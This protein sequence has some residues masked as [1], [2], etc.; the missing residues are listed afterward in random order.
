MGA[1]PHL[2]APADRQGGGGNTH[3]HDDERPVTVGNLSAARCQEYLEAGQ[4]GRVAWSAAHGPQIFPVSYAWC[5]DLIVFRT[6]PYSVLSE[7]TRRTHVVFEVEELD[8]VSHTGWSVLAR[9]CATGI[10]SP[11]QLFRLW[12]VDGAEPW[13]AG[14]RNVFIGISVTQLSGRLFDPPSAHRTPGATPAPG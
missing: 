6:S 7:L 2:P 8:Q 12:A 5:D 11:A 10:A 9:G 1:H 4:V 3:A 13:A 14:I